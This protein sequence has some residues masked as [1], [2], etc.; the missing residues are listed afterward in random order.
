V[1]DG[2]SIRFPRVTRIRNDKTVDTATN[3]QE[4]NNLYVASK[5]HEDFKLGKQSAPLLE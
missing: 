4:L 2:I 3:L 1:A 5:K